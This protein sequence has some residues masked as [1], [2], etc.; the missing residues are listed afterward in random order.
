MLPLTPGWVYTRESKALGHCFSMNHKLQG[1][2]SSAAETQEVF[3]NFTSLCRVLATEWGEENV[4]N[5]KL[6]V[7]ITSNSEKFTPKTI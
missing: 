6:D 1:K 5:Y 3:N 4:F 2:T 7:F